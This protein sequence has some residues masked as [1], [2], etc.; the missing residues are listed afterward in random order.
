[1]FWFNFSVDQKSWTTEKK[2]D[3]LG[4]RASRATSECTLR[5]E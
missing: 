2:D 5:E 4:E 1:M 3:L